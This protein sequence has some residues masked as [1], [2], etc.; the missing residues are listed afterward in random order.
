MPTAA[1]KNCLFGLYFLKLYII[2]AYMCSLDYISKFQLFKG[3]FVPLICTSYV[4]V[5]NKLFHCCYL[6]YYVSFIR[7]LFP[8]YEM[9]QHCTYRDNK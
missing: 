4:L 7:V 8:A 3:V 9:L 1:N 2:S 6:S 5:K